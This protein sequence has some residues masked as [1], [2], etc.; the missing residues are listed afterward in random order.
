M[1]HDRADAGRQLAT[2]VADSEPE[3]PVV[4]GMARGGVPVAA[5]VAQ[6]LGAPLEA[7]VVRKVGCPWQPEL[8]VGALAEDGVVLFNEE[9]MAE[10]DLDRAALEPVLA[11]ERTLLEERVRRYRGSRLPTDLSGRHAILVDD[12]LATGFTARAAI[13]ALRRRGAARVVLAVP[14]APPGTATELADVADEVIVVLLPRD[15]RAI[16]QFYERFDQTT[17]EEVV[18]LLSEA[19]AGTAALGTSGAEA[20]PGAQTGPRTSAEAGP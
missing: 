20:E 1:F 15:L 6:R 5:V 3:A 16:G 9:L 7:L 2:R 4:V 11:R 13:E 10:L 19:S 17:D 18:R 8:G 12:G 14:V